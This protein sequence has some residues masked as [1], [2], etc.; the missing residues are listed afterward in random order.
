M[1]QAMESYIVTYKELR[2][3]GFT[4]PDGR[5]GLAASGI[6]PAMAEAL[7]ACPF[8]QDDTVAA[9]LVLSDG[10]V[11][12]KEVYFTTRIKLGDEILDAESASSLSVAPAYR[13]LAVGAD[14]VMATFLRSRLFLGAGVSEMALPLDRKLKFHVLEFPRLM[15]LRNAKPLLAARHLSWLGGVANLPLGW[16]HK[17][18]LRKAGRL[19]RKFRIEQVSTVP[20]WVDDIVLRDGHKYAECHDHK[21]LQW[22]LD[23]RFNDHPRS[24]QALFCVFQDG[25]PLGFYMLKERFKEK[26]GG[27]ENVLVGSLVEWGTQDDGRLTESGLLLLSLRDFSSGVDIVETATAD[28]NT[29]RAVRKYGFIPHGKANIVF[30]DRTKK[31]ADAADMGQ[32]RVRFGC[33]DVI[34]T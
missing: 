26:A 27:L 5:P 22:N 6:S 8:V 15:Q 33:G 2:E 4:L 24:R 10:A 18:I 25:E 3:G 31:Y 7:A 17:L 12:G 13:Q 34:L 9:Y 28:E 11:V 1:E 21:W 23:H 14:I 30:K 16:F 32:W 19:A 20:G 29:A